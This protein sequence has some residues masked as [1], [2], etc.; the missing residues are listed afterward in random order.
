MP[1]ALKFCEQGKVAFF[2]EPVAPADVNLSRGDH[3]PA[4]T[5]AVVVEN[6]GIG[7]A[8][9]QHKINFEAFQQAD[10]ST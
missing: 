8:P 3:D 7:I 9:E 4:Q 6:T 1:N 5:L 2:L 10:G